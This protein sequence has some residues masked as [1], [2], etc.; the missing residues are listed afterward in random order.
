MYTMKD[1]R[2]ALAER[3][4]ND[5]GSGAWNLSQAK[6]TAIVSVL[7]ACGN[8]QMVSEVVGEVYNLNDCGMEFNSGAVQLDLWLLESN[9]YKAEAKELRELCWN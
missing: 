3:D 6:I 9:G 7:V 4:S 5:M 2:A 1:Y 8:T